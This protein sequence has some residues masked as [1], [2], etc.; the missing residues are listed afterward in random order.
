M[1]GRQWRAGSSVLRSGDL[2]AR[3]P[4]PYDFLPS[5]AGVPPRWVVDK[6]HAGGVLIGNMIGHPQH[7]EKA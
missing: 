6:L 5:T 7:V 3:D 2:R 4:A 1:A